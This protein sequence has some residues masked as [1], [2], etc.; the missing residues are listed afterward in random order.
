MSYNQFA[1]IYDA[2]MYDQPYDK[3]FEIVH[4]YLKDNLLDLATGTGSFISLIPKSISVTGVD[5]SEEMLSIA[6][7][8]RPDV[9]LIAQDM[10]ELA[11]NQTFQT[12]T[13]LCDSLNYLET[14]VDVMSTFECVNRHLGQ[15]GVFIFD[16]HSTLKF[17]AYFNN[18]T[19]SDELPG[20]V[21]IWHAIEAEK[22]YAVHHDLTFFIEEND[23]YHRFDE[24]HYQRTFEIED[25][26]EMLSQT[27]FKVEKIFF[28]FDPTHTIDEQTSHYFDRVFFVAK[29]I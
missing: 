16:V 29:K 11:L 9:T 17:D 24:Q 4:P 7:M 18:Q 14:K 13:C 8:K 5:L 23:A 12:I 6:A 27:G 3:W 19:Y 28:D 26:H 2:F 1:S 25:Y 10:R 22:P 21:Y 15:D 20:M